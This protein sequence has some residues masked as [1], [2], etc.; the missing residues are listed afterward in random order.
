MSSVSHGL[1]H[2]LVFVATSPAKEVPVETTDVVEKT[3][4]KAVG[5]SGMAFQTSKVAKNA[6]I[7]H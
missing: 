7:R 4:S 2:D 6:T 1:S 5:N 3:E